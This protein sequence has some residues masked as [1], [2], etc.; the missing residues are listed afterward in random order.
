MVKF[1]FR[2]MFAV[3]LCWLIGTG[4]AWSADFQ[5]LTAQALKAK[6]DKGEKFFLLN[7][8]SDIEFAEGHIPGSVNIPLH[9]IKSSDKLPADKATP[10]VT[11][12]LGPK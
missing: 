10:I 4:I 2:Y 11:Y 8:L 6:M 12:C 1:P 9:R 3:G 7:P 5:D